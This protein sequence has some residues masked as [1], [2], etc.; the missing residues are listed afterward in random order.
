MIIHI[1]GDD[2]GVDCLSTYINKHAA[3]FKALLI[4]YMPKYNHTTPLPDAD[5]DV[6][7][8]SMF[9]SRVKGQDLVTLKSVA[10][11]VATYEFDDPDDINAKS[12]AR[13][14]TQLSN[15]VDIL[16]DIDKQIDNI[17]I[18]VGAAHLN[19]GE[20]GKNATEKGKWKSHVTRLREH[21]PAAEIKFHDATV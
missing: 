6:E 20:G 3:S 19:D 15:I 11:K 8:E 21:F 16:N 10:H 12:L 17:C 5:I 7:L 18:I 2:H 13:H 1:I 9:D 14:E 4:E